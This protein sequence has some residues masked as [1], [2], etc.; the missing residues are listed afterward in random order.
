MNTKTQ[1]WTLLII[2]FTVF[3]LASCGKEEIKDND[4]K[5]D[6]KNKLLGLCIEL[7]PTDSLRTYEFTEQDSIIQKKLW[8]ENDDRL[9]YYFQII[10]ICRSY[11]FK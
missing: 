7:S 5:Q 11:S 2:S 9:S 8:Y 4:Y 6:I 10:A 3:N 1:I